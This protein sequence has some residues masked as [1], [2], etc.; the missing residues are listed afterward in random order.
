MWAKTACG[1]SSSS[2]W[3]SFGLRFRV[4]ENWPVFWHCCRA[5]LL[6]HNQ[7]R[8]TIRIPFV[9]VAF[10][11]KN[12]DVTWKMWKKRITHQIHDLSLCMRVCIHV[13]VWR[14]EAQ[15]NLADRHTIIMVTNKIRR[16]SMNKKNTVKRKKT[17]RIERG[18][19]AKERERNEIGSTAYMHPD[20][21]PIEVQLICAIGRRSEKGTNGNT[22]SIR[23]N[24]HATACVR[25]S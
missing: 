24:I 22:D 3:N 20:F 5:K 12:V 10:R 1:N 7:R 13:A 16:N 14:I 17:E 6:T 15:K 8:K 11:H 25:I 21:V 23:T 2:I 9:F 18:M 4:D 19:K